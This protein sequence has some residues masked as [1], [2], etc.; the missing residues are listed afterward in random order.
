M[1]WQHGCP[2]DKISTFQ[3]QGREFNTCLIE[4]WTFVFVFSA[5]ANPASIQNVGKTSR[6]FCW[7]LAYKGKN[8]TQMDEWS[9]CQLSFL[10]E[11]FQACHEHLFYQQETS[12]CDASFALQRTWYQ[13]GILS[14]T[15]Y[16]LFVLHSLRASTPGWTALHWHHHDKKNY[17]QR[18][19]LIVVFIKLEK[20]FSDH[21]C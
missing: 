19:C 3:P 2:S 9:L 11:Y 4:C 17:L 16:R 20:Y 6:I 15:L 8:Q 14:P 12:E 5:K 21:I 13:A 7:G 18:L 1:W 10:G